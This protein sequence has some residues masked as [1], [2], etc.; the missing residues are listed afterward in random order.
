MDIPKEYIDLRY[1]IPVDTVVDV[2]CVDESQRQAI[3]YSDWHRNCWSNPLTQ[4]RWD[5][6]KLPAIIGW[7]K[8]CEAD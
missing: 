7:K 6:D 3:I 5:Q 4:R 1:N 2:Y 8:T